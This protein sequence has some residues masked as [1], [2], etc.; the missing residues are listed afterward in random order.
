MQL[1]KYCTK[2]VPPAWRRI[3]RSH[4]EFYWISADIVQLN[5]G[6]FCQH[7]QLMGFLFRT[8]RHIRCGCRLGRY[9]CARI[10]FGDSGSNR[11]WDIGPRAVQFMMDDRWRRT[12]AAACYDIRQKRHS[13]FCLK[14]KSSRSEMH[15]F[16]E[17]E[18]KSN[19]VINF[20]RENTVTQ[21][22]LSRI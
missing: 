16:N 20:I 1:R 10:K 2:Q 5:G 22:Y 15:T 4:T 21:A 6:S 19:S 8:G 13:A 11:S 14:T 17:N 12:T 18:R 3:I 9:G 7:H